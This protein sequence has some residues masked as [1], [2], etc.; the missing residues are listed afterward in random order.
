MLGEIRSRIVGSAYSSFVSFQHLA[1]FLAGFLARLLL[2]AALDFD[3]AFRLEPLLA[4][5]RERL[6]DF[7]ADRE[8]LRFFPADDLLRLLHFDALRKLC[9][10]FR[11]DEAVR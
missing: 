10:V 8:R 9:P 11:I 2:E 5:E 1:F 3:A 6:M 7:E 4:L